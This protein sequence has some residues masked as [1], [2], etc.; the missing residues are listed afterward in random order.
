MP[1]TPLDAPPHVRLR[2]AVRLVAAA[3]GLVLAA[4]CM[5]E[6]GGSSAPAPAAGSVGPGSDALGALREPAGTDLTRLPVGD[7]RVS[8]ERPARGVVFI[9]QPG[10]GGGGADA[11]GPW[12]HGDTFDL[13][14]KATVDGAVR[15]PQAQMRMEQRAGRLVLTGN[16]LPVGSTTGAFPVAPSDDAYRWDRN[17]NRIA[18]QSVRWSLPGR[19]APAPS[20]SCLPKGP[21]GLATNGVAL[22]NAVD[23]NDKDAVAHEVQDTCAGHPEATSLYHY[24][25]IS[26]CLTREG[27]RGLVGWALDG[28][29]ILGPDDSAGRPLTNADLDECHGRTETIRLGGRTV[30]TYVHRATAEYPYT[31]GCFRGTPVRSTRDQRPRAGRRRVRRHPRRRGPP[32]RSRLVRPSP[33]P[34]RRRDHPR[35]PAPAALPTGAA[36][37]ARRRDRRDRRCRP[38]RPDCRPDRRCRLDRRCR[39]DRPE[40]KRHARRPDRVGPDPGSSVDPLRSNPSQVVPIRTSSTWV[41]W[42]SRV[43]RPS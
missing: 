33:A 40:R 20:P 41:R 5:S 16:G 4:S 35:P 27:R 6:A 25:S 30:R 38:D 17:P 14:A 21:I 12:I 11:D 34:L 26:G 24:H 19:P 8:T 31:L 9:C 36:S 7:G 32:R 43:P 15:W 18:A 10:T 37:P 39:P 29:P 1:P 42:R 13:T 2:R 22:F 28:F 3:V 23:L